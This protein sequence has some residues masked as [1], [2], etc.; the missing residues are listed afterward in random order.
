[1]KFKKTLIKDLFIGK[2][3]GFKDNRGTFTRMYSVDIFKKKFNFNFKQAN[4]CTN[5]KKGTFRGLHYQVGKYKE[6]KVIQ[7]LKG[8]TFHIIVDIRK[9][10]KTYKSFFTYYLKERKNDFLVIPKGCAHGYLT[11]KQNSTIVY[12]TTNFYNKEF[13][14]G[15]NIQDPLLIKLKLPNKIRI[16]SNQD[17]LWKKIKL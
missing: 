8:K 1:M 16:I 14:R 5:P 2:Q 9:K 10:S 7:I 17:S 13:S 11:L 4:M 15:I 12:F 3:E 6:D